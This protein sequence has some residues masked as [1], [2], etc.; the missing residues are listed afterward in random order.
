MRSGTLWASAGLLVGVGILAS[1]CTYTASEEQAITSVAEDLRLADF[2][3]V[4][5]QSWYRP[6]LAEVGNPLSLTL[7]IK[8]SA[9]LDSVAERLVD[10]EFERQISSVEGETNYTRN[11]T[12]KSGDYVAARLIVHGPGETGSDVGVG[13]GS[14]GVPSEGMVE[15]VIFV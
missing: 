1:G 6:G 15:I 9:N 7:A 12:P 13:G 5:C 3:G 4:E 8:D 14:C 11:D 2:G 10:L